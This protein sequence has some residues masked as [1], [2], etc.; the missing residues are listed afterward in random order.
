ML[1][2]QQIQMGGKVTVT[3]LSYFFLQQTELLF[4]KSC[5]LSSKM[6]LMTEQQISHSS[7]WTSRSKPAQH[8]W[9]CCWWEKT[10]CQTG[11]LWKAFLN[12][13]ARF[14]KRE[15][16]ASRWGH[17]VALVMSSENFIELPIKMLALGIRSCDLPQSFC[18]EDTGL[19]K[20]L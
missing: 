19:D 12:H 11:H 6:Q 13:M 15:K 9:T 3:V 7:I 10:R 2:A 18:F 17:S 4:L 8:F 16:Q 1:L 14:L 20:L 5:F